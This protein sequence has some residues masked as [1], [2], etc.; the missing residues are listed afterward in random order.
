MVLRVRHRLR[1]AFSALYTL[2]NLLWAQSYSVAL[3]AQYPLKRKG[4]VL[5]LLRFAISYL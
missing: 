3:A 4:F 1:L 2:R 5:I